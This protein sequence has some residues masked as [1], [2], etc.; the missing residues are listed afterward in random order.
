MVFVPWYFSF[1]IHTLFYDICFAT[2]TKVCTWNKLSHI[3]Y[4]TYDMDMH[5]KVIFIRELEK[6]LDDVAGNGWP[7]KTK[8]T[9]NYSCKPP[10][11]GAACVT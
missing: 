9:K 2:D 7:E 1:R 11:K 5:L 6:S 4:H 10:H 8:D 3:R